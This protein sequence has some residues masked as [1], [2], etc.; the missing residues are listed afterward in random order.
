MPPSK[1]KCRVARGFSIY[2]EGEGCSRQDN[3]NKR[4]IVFCASSG[5]VGC[6]CKVGHGK[7][8]DFHHCVSYSCRG[9]P[10][11]TDECQVCRLNV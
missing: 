8:S 11:G 7:R 1:G 10:P 6:C 3:R 2:D 4:Q 9:P 5:D